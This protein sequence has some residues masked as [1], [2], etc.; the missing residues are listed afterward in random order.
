MSETTQ[1][2]A[3]FG[4]IFPKET[5][6]LV[7]KHKSKYISRNQYIVRAVEHYLSEKDKVIA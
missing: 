3:K 7:E 6:D 4:V 2:I 5:L 1:Q